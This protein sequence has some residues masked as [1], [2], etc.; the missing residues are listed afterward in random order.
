[1]AVKFP[2][3]PCCVGGCHLPQAACRETEDGCAW[4]DAQQGSIPM[5]DILMLALA[6][7]F[8]ALAIGYTYA[9]ERL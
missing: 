5:M 9:C 1:M 6:F 2:S 4:D 8:F 3:W 7:G